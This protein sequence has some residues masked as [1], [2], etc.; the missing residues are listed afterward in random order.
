V[1]RWT[2]FSK[3]RTSARYSRLGTERAEPNA[4]HTRI[5]SD[6]YA[7]EKKAPVDG[8][9][10]AKSADLDTEGILASSMLNEPLK[11]KQVSERP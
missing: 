2:A 4:H 8:T 6:N 10:I 11:T 9:R 5:D 1:S 7:G 3:C